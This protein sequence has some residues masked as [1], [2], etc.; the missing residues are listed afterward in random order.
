ME[1]QDLL[2]DVLEVSPDQ[3]SDSTG[4]INLSNWDSLR[5]IEVVLALESKYDVRFSVAEVI[6]IDSLASVREL[7]SNKGVA[8]A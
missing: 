4:P 3:I 7:L 2:A 5:H 1:L 6:A 8:V